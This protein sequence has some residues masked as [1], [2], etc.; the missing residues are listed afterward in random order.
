MSMILISAVAR[1]NR[2]IGTENGL[3]WS[4]P[5]EY[6]HFLEKTRGHPVIMGRK[7]YDILILGK[8]QEYEKR[9]DSKMFVVSRSMEVSDGIE[10]QP[11]GIGDEVRGA[12]PPEDLGAKG[13]VLENPIAQPLPKPLERVR[14][15]EPDLPVPPNGNRL[16]P[17]RPHHGPKSPSCGHSIFIIHDGRKSHPVFPS[18]ADARHR[19][20]VI[21]KLLFDGPLRLS[22][23]HTLEFASVVEVDLPIL[24]AEVGPVLRPPLEDQDIKASAPQFRAKIL[25]G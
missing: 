22:G 9:P 21:S 13:G 16:Q 2:V 4:I 3:P 7:T 14:A 23:P 11:I 10:A 12:I 6:E 17:F 15:G 24:N 8:G 18:R 1:R 5:E 19:E 20:P 25:A